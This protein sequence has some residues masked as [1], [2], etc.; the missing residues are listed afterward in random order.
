M[1]Y[2]DITCD[3]FRLPPSHPILLHL[4]IDPADWFKFEQ[5]ADD[6]PATRIVGRDEPRDERM[7]VHVACASEETRRRLEDGWG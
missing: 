4:R 1:R 6:N 3:R 7:I 2:H 5:M